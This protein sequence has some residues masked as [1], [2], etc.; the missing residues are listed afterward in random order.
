MRAYFLAASAVLF[1]AAPAQAGPAEEA[2]AAVTTWLDKFNAGDADAF[3]A[4]HADGAVIIDEFPPY[5]WGGPQSAQRWLADYMKDAE[6][7]GISG[8]RVDYDKSALQATSD[9]KSAYVVLPTTYRFKQKDAKMAG[10]GS[11]TF[12]LNR[13]GKEWKIATWT[14]SGATPAPE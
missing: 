2:T 12:V 8:G 11:M 3:Y 13:S 4:A 9:G 7:K 5:V 10:K 6:A 1:L 14:Y